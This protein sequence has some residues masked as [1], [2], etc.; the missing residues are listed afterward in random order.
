MED[1]FSTIQKKK[2]FYLKFIQRDQTLANLLHEYLQTELIFLSNLCLKI[3]R[4]GEAFQNCLKNSDRLREL[5]IT[6]VF[7]SITHTSFFYTILTNYTM[8]TKDKFHMYTTMNQESGVYSGRTS[9]KEYEFQMYLKHTRPNS[10]LVGSYLTGR[11]IMFGKEIPDVYDK[12]LK[13]AIYFQV[14]YFVS[15]KPLLSPH[16]F[17]RL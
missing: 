7:S 15:E 17:C 12:S 5:P 14:Q 3:E 9:K 8:A 4:T 6:S 16:Y 2:Q 11:P 1:S 10:D 13:E